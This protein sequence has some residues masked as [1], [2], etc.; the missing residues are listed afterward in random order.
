[1]AR[2]LKEEVGEVVTRLISASKLRSLLSSSQKASEDCAEIKGALG[3]EL[4]TAKEKHNLHP[5]AFNTIKGLMGWEPEKLREFK[6]HF[7]FYWEASGLEKRAD[8]APRLSLGD[9]PED[10]VHQLSGAA[11]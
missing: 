3:E 6:D 10:N 8:S 5:K 1:M 9:E 11:E 2:K 4:K 7:D